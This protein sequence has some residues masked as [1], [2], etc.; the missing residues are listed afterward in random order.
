MKSVVKVPSV[1]VSDVWKRLRLW[2]GVVSF[3]L[4]SGCALA[5]PPRG[6]VIDETAGGKAVWDRQAVMDQRDAYYHAMLSYA[7]RFRNL[8][9]EHLAK[10]AT[11]PNNGMDQT[12]YKRWRHWWP[13]R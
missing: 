4:F 7:Y 8:L 5:N 2:T 6:L 3:L 13:I 10:A 1:C 9:P 12:R 11:S